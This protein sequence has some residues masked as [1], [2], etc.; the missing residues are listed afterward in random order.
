MQRDHQNLSSARWSTGKNKAVIKKLSNVLLT[1]N[2]GCSTKYFYLI[3]CNMPVKKSDRKRSW[4]SCEA[5][6]NGHPSHTDNIAL[7]SS[8]TVLIIV[9]SNWP[10]GP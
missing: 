5:L 2:I 9:Q 4:L 10:V 7:T 6:K 3:Y 1:K 8:T